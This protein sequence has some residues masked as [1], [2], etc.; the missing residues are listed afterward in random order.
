MTP[1]WEQDAARAFDDEHRDLLWE[2]RDIEPDPAWS[3]IV[4]AAETAEVIPAGHEVLPRSRET[5][6]W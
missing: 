5:D 4:S 2:H 1:E 3:E 6:P